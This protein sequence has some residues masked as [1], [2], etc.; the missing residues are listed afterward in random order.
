ML[1]EIIVVR[2][3]VQMA[4]IRTYSELRKLKTF[5]ERFEY[6]KL[7]GEIGLETFGFDRYFNQRFYKSKE[8][9]QSRDDVII[10]DD[11][12]DLGI[13]DYEIHGRIIVHH[14]NP[15]TLE[16]LEKQT[17]LLLNPEYLIT[18]THATHNAIHYGDITLLDNTIIERRANDTCLWRH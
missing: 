8:W 4:I 2:V 13:K 12:C 1:C 11:G 15:I 10:R 3:V 17:E 6:L 5:K 14:L 7:D 16:D 18:T 9:L